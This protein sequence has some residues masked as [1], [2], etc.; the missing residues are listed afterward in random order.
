MWIQHHPNLIPCPRWLLVLNTGCLL[1]KYTPTIYKVSPRMWTISCQPFLSQKKQIQ[2]RQL[3]KGN[4][5]FSRFT[6]FLFS[7]LSMQQGAWIKRLKPTKETEAVKFSLTVPQFPMDWLENAWHKL[8]LAKDHLLSWGFTQ[9]ATTLMDL[10]T[11]P[12][13]HNLDLDLSG[14]L[15]SWR[16]ILI[17]GQV[18]SPKKHFGLT[19][20]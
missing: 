18:T 8:W 2:G 19:E 11:Y 16:S 10:D 3:K 1:N 13:T 6:F 17:I 12:S 5:T 20:F 4:L 9:A 15:S 14:S 7:V